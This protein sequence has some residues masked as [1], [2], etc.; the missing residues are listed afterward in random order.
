MKKIAVFCAPG[1]EEIEALTVADYLRRAN[2]DVLIVSV[3]IDGCPKQDIIVE[4]AHKIKIVA[5][6]LLQ[7]FIDQVEKE[8]LPD[9]IY[10]PGG[11]QGAKNLHDN[12]YIFQMITKM[13]SAGKIIASIC[14][15]PAVVLVPTGIISGRNWTCYPGMEKGIAEFCHSKKWSIEATENSHHIKD[16]PFVFDNNVLTGRGPGTTEQFAM[17]L[18]EILTDKKTAKKIHDESCQR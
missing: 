9:A 15:S 14:A 1:F 13:D 10:L 16:V 3:P 4:G 6:I 8:G 18:V 17:K 5:D 2:L 7:D 11:S 12:Q